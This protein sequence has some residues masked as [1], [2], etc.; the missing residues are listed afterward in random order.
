[1]LRCSKH[2]LYEV[3]SFGQPGARCEY[4]QFDFRLLGAYRTSQRQHQ[5]ACCCG[6]Q[7]KRN[8]ATRR[9]LQVDNVDLD[10]IGVAQQKGRAVEQQFALHR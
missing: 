6:R 1:M 9:P 4:P 3:L 2:G 5:H 8:R 10:L 7:A